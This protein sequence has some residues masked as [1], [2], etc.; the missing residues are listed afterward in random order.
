MD[1]GRTESTDF[2]REILDDQMNTIP[3]AGAGLATVGHRPTGRACRTAEQQSKITARDLGKG[4][5]SLGDERK[6]EVRCIER[7]G[8][9][10]VIDH[11]TYMDGGHWASSARPR[12]GSDI[13]T[14]YR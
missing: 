8:G 6:T 14:R 9:L 10:D 5:Q 3:T 7:E 13:R 1:A 4:R 11:V 12:L 2:C